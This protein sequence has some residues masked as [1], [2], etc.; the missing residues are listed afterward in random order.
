MI[1]TA[2]SQENRGSASTIDCEKAN[3]DDIIQA[4]Q[5]AVHKGINLPI[6]KDLKHLNQNQ[7]NEEQMQHRRQIKTE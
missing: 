3:I 5:E 4:L 7:R 1:L 6:S 2:I